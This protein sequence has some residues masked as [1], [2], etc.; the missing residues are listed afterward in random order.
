MKGIY[1]AQINVDPDSPDGQ[2][3]NN[4][5]QEAL[6]VENLLVQVNA[7]FDPDQ[8]VGSILDQRVTIN[9]IQREAG[10]FTITNITLVIS[11]A[12]NLFGLDQ[13]DNQVF[14]VQDN[15]GNQ[16]ELQTTQTIASAGTYVRSFQAANPGQ[17]FTT[18]NT[19]Q[20]PVTIVLGVVS[21]NNPTTYTTLGINE[22]LDSKLRIRRLK[23]VSLSSQG[24]LAGLEAALDNINGVTTAIV[25]ENVGDVPN[26]DGVP[27]HSIWVIVAGGAS[28][29]IAQAIYSKRNAGCGMKGSI[30]Y[31]I[32]QRDGTTFVVYWDT[33]VP[34]DLFIKFTATSLDGINPP[35]IAAIRSGLVTSLA[36]AVNGQV[37]INELST[38]VQDIDSNALVT[39]AGFSA[40]IGGS[41]TNTLLPSAKNFQFAV[42]SANITIL[43]MILSPTVS[44]VIHSTV[45]QFT[46]LG[47]HGTLTYS[48]A[49]NNS[50]GTINSSTGLYTAGSTP[51]VTDTILVTDSL[52]NTAS[53]T[54]NVT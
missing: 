38:L 41:Y 40:S 48:F 36:P 16:W 30:S 31:G 9:G 7:Q 23:S 3:L 22:E 32:L 44:T 42:T 8:A 25:I 54:V 29:S 21:V 11:Q 28:A 14:T 50:G 10:T 27:G 49:T 35:N 51:N 52:S 18:P 33:V 43:P 1:G 19:I 26:G 17:V 34:Q 46:G 13:T 53:A 47:G 20:T 39:L 45:E 24:Y 12:C 37:N 2:W 15:A 6:D 5:V 4:I